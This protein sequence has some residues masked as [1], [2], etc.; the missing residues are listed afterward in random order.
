MADTFGIATIQANVTA[1]G[2]AYTV[3]ETIKDLPKAFG[4]VKNGTQFVRSTLETAG[5]TLENS[6]PADY[7]TI[8]AIVQKCLEDSAK[9]K[10]I[11]QKLADKCNQIPDQKGWDEVRVWYLEAIGNDKGFRVEC[12]TKRLLG[13]LR[14][15]CSHESVMAISFVKDVDEALK[16]LED[17]G[18]SLEDSDFDRSASIY[19]SQTVNS[20]GFA[21]QN[22]PTGGTNVFNSG[23]NISGGYVTYGHVP[24]PTMEHRQR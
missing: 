6:E 16:K 21:Q 1:I 15:V 5:P 22:T 9:V 18:A 2:A 10:K 24:T 13:N 12:L 20:G 3:I 11:F 17:A 8:S 23:H 7:H 19:N 4:E 14:K